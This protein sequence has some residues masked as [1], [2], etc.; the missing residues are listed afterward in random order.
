MGKNQR[1][2]GI[3]ES[4]PVDVAVLRA[5]D[6]RVRFDA[7]TELLEYVC[8]ENEKDRQHFV[9]PQAWLWA[10]LPLIV[11]VTGSLAQ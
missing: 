1:N 11:T 8:N 9:Q 10:T 3:P 2:E 7:D 5:Q 6:E 4:N